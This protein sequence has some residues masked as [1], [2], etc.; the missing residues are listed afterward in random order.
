MRDE[1][2]ARRLA[3]ALKELGRLRLVVDACDHSR[4][5]ASREDM[6]SLADRI[7]A[8][9][10]GAWREY[11]CS[12]TLATRRAVGETITRWTTLWLEGTQ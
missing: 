3:D 8:E 4:M 9:L 2:L 11:R 7:E 12:P 10:L 5:L 6:H 1:E